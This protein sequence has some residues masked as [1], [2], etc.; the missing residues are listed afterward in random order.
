[1]AIVTTTVR[2]E[3]LCPFGSAA[4]P[5]VR[6][7]CFPHAGGVPDTFRLWPAGLAVAAGAEVGVHAVCY[8]GRR[9]RLHEAT[10]NRMEP[11]ADAVAAA[12]EPLTDRPL[13]LFGHSM[14]ASVAHEVAR[15]LVAAGRPPALLAVSGREAPHAL[16]PRGVVAGGDAA[17]VADVVALDPR[18]RDVLADPGLRELVLPP[19]RADYEL[20][21]A[22]GPRV[23]LPLPVPVMAYAGSAD[24]V[25]T[26]AD[27][28]AWSSAT[29]RE[30]GCRVFAGGHFFLDEHRGELLDDLAGRIRRHVLVA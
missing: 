13:V 1:V 21:E 3:W 6:V 14:G 10:V 15:R 25:T 30:F 9:D 5:D 28:R 4:A 12:L 20:V 7:V 18:A 11:V 22:Y 8:P 24:P 16:R 26:V 29:T 23:L 17:I 19:I 27:V 2:S